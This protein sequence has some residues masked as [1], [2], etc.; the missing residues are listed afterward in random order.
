MSLSILLKN[1]VAS[2]CYRTGSFER[3]RREQAKDKAFILTYHRVLSAKNSG[4][5]F[6]QPGMYVTVDTFRQHLDFLK[7]TFH[8]LPL[9][10]LAA[11]IESGKSVGGCC[12]ITFDDG[13]HDNYTEAFPVIRDFQVPVTIFLASAFIGTKRMFWPEELTF[14][15]RQPE[16]KAVMSQGGVGRLPTTPAHG[17]EEEFL[18]AVVQTVKSY[19]PAEREALMEQLRSVSPMAPAGRMLLDWGE[20]EAMQ[21][22]GF[23]SFGAHTANHVILDQVP[24]PVA[25]EEIV[26]S[27]ND[28][29][30]RLGQPTELFAY[31]NGNYSA[32]LQ[33]ILRRHGFRAA[34][35][36]RKGWVGECANLLA[37][38]RIAIHE[39]VSSTLP[40][41][42]A[43]ILLE[44][45]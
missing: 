1:I 38:P 45:F 26:R 15:L 41:F 4:Q 19:Q 24:L 8:I 7:D 20:I 23:V 29:E 13:W 37:I 33:A 10:E 30:A 28:I 27:R 2:A 9:H 16:A 34:M 18:D 43:R 22:S 3:L 21:S 5:S 12:A 40:L 17:G 14:Y 42:F 32:D 44:R 25:E 31:P 6:V 36:T 35:T 39:D 11:R